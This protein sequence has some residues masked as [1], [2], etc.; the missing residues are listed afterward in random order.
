MALGA[1]VGYL[2]WR[3]WF[4]QFRDTLPWQD[5]LPRFKLVLAGIMSTSRTMPGGWADR[6]ALPKGEQG[7]PL[8]RWCNLEVPPRRFTFCSDW[9]VHEWKLR[10]DPGYLRDQFFAGTEVFA[11]CAAST[12]SLAI[13]N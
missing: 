6:S 10:T 2:Q 1:P 11:A 9:C 3:C 7:R 8:C 13:S 4:V 5:D 12:R